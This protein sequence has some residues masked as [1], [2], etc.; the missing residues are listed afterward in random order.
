MIFGRIR[1]LGPFAPSPSVM[2]TQSGDL[3]LQMVFGRAV[4]LELQRGDLE[5]AALFA[6]AFLKHRGDPRAAA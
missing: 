3:R 1:F 2:A 4:L 6:R 5:K